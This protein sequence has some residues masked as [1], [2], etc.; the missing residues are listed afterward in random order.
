MQGWDFR[1]GINGVKRMQAAY[2]SALVAQGAF[3]AYW[4]DDVRAAGGWPD[5]IGEDIVLTWTLMSTRG[6][7]Q[8]EPCALAFTSAPQ[9]LKHFMRQRSRWARGMFE[10]IRTVPPVRQPRVLAKFVAGIDYLVPFLDIGYI[11]FWIPGLILFVFGYPLIVSWVS[12]LVIPIT[13]TVYW[14]LRRWQDGTCSAAST[15]IRSATRADS[16]A[17]CSPTRRSRRRRRSGATSS[18]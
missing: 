13:V 2:N 16:G 17:T 12:M 3:S 1:L 7:V 18:T 14:L 8:Y 10:T 4:T 5:A 9:E 6:I 11:F 15:S